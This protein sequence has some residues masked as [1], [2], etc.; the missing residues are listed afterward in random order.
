MLGDCR[1]YMIL[2]QQLS[3]QNLVRS[4][5][6]YKLAAHILNEMLIYTIELLQKNPTKLWHEKKRVGVAP[7]LPVFLMNLDAIFEN[8]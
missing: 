1:M 4:Q 5:Q 2:K 3:Q 8:Q 7:F 6:S